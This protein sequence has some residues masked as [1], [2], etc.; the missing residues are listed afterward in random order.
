[1]V[2][3]MYKAAFIMRGTTVLKGGVKVV[4]MAL[5]FPTEEITFSYLSSSLLRPDFSMLM[6]TS[7]LHLIK[8][9]SFKKSEF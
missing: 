4:K 8:H 6:L 9:L 1:M 5:L 2:I 7:L 3:D